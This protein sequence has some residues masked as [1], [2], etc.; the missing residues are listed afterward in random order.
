MSFIDQVKKTTGTIGG[1]IK[2]TY[3]PLEALELPSNEK[4]VYRYPLD[5]ATSTIYPHTI[6][7]QTWL[8]T[9]VELTE[10]EPFQAVA[11]GTSDAASWA[12]SKLGG[13]PGKIAGAL[14]GA[15]RAILGAASK[16]ETK[17]QN[18]TGLNL[19]DY[20]PTPGKASSTGS[21][22]PTAMIGGPRV[23]GNQVFNN[24]LMDFTRRAVPSDLI[25]L[26]LPAGNWQDTH[27]NQYEGKS[28]TEAYGAAGVVAE[29]GSSAIE[30][31]KQQDGL[32]NKVLSSISSVANSPV[33]AQKGAELL[34][35]LA[36]GDGSAVAQVTLQA[37]GT[38]QNPQM[39]MLYGGTDFRTFQFEFILTPRNQKEAESIRE[40]IRKFKYHA[41]PQMRSDGAGRFI[42]PPS[43]FDI[44]MKFNGGDSPYLPRI[45][46]CALT[47][48]TIQ[49]NNGLDQ[50]ASFE[51]GAPIQ[52]TMTLQF[53]ELEMM[54]KT[55]R[56]QGY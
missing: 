55:L 12:N 8:P 22:L 24:R 48:I 4:G 46:T 53:T 7:F 33:V 27:K 29:I 43:Y 30:G 6:E 1:V 13:V 36:G 41:S 10:L 35:T 32:V 50:W 37:M 34:G 21:T 45:S 23:N 16:L 17:L 20:D 56:E 5:V 26:Y 11:K 49:Y 2:R 52:A 39:E 40:I 47:D 15:G 44:T 19:W 51:D 54:H 3:G 14:G 9:P 38:A 18:A 31:A 28:M 42:T 25:V